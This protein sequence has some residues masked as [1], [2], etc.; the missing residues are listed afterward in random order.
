MKRSNFNI[1]PILIIQKSNYP[2]CISIIGF[3][4]LWHYHVKVYR[5]RSGPGA[6]NIWGRENVQRPPP[7]H[8]LTM[9]RIYNERESATEIENGRKRDRERKKDEKEQKRNK[10]K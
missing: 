3:N 6:C 8:V 10:N 9:K 1:M 5:I 7:P 4:L 2:I